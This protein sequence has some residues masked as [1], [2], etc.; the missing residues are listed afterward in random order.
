MK[1][2]LAAPLCFVACFVVGY[3]AGSRP[4]T[5]S[6]TKDIERST[7]L[8]NS[9]SAEMLG[10][11][12][13]EELVEFSKPAPVT[14]PTP[15][16]VN[17][18]IPEDFEKV[19]FRPLVPVFGDADGAN[20]GRCEVTDEMKH[21]WLGMFK[22]GQTYSLERVKVSFGKP[23]ADDFG[24]FIPM[25]FADSK[26][27]LYLFGDDDRIRPGPVR[28]LYEMPYGGDNESLIGAGFRKEFEIGGRLYTLRVTSGASEK[29]SP[30][31]VAVL[32]SGGKRD[33]LYFRPEFAGNIGR[34]EWVGDLDN[35]QQLDVLFSF[36]AINGG[37]KNYILFLSSISGSEHLVRPYAFFETRFRGC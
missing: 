31:S 17:V 18:H 2:L 37:G 24:V 21:P 36:F 12:I 9:S 5:I 3:F 23:Q 29:N 26:N 14:A 8:I 20:V 30:V 4:L 15:E 33:F 16:F 10:V 28:T 35:D 22:R 27:A 34:F 1:L 25:R 7:P 11:V 19:D 6:Q 32:E 13:S